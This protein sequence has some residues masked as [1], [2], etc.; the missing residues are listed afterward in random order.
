MILDLDFVGP[1]IGYLLDDRGAIFKTTNGGGNW[2]PLSGVGSP[3]Y[4]V[5]FS[6]PLNGY[7]AIAGFGSIRTGGVV[8]RT[9]DGG[10]S[11]HPQLVSPFA[12]AEHRERRLDRLPPRRDECPVRDRRRRGRRRRLGSD[13]L[14]PSAFAERSRAVWS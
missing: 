5:E 6:S 7:V 11:W 12:V 2:K 8:L 4:Q 9:T 1:N 13:D 3:G 10:R 14:R